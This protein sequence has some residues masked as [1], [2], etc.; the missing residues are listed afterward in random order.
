[1]SQYP[2]EEIKAKYETGK[3]TM[4]ELADEYGFNRD[5]GF[6]KA[7]K[8]GWEKGKTNKSIRKE[9]T[10]KVIEDEAEKEA[11]LRQEY[12]K[13]INNIRRGMYNTLFKEKDFERLKQFKIASET[14][15]NLRKEQWEVNEILEVA[16]KAEL[17]NQEDKLEEF[18]DAVQNAE[19][20]D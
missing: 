13:I 7:G 19:V 11:K 1:M 10:K 15:R 4:Q 3:Y 14:I 20:V 2:W 6:Q 12:E 9:A 16:Q 5:Y 17:D 8:K 18:V